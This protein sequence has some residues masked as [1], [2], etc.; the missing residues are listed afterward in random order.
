MA[1]SGFFPGPCNE[2]TYGVPD[3][4]VY[5]VNPCCTNGSISWSYPRGTLRLYFAPTDLK[6]YKF[7]VCFESYANGSTFD[8]LDVT[9]GDKKPCRRI[10][11]TEVCTD[12]HINGVL[13]DVEAK[14]PLRYMDEIRYRTVTAEPKPPVVNLP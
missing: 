5:N 6:D 10:S 11:D 1:K 14:G 4:Q 13:A 2:K 7:A 9:N 3:G 12:Y 8:V